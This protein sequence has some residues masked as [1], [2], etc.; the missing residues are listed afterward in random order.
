MT[1]ADYKRWLSPYVDEQLE[2]AR[3]AE[4][5]EHLGGCAG[6]RSEL[7]S[8]QRMLASLR[9]MAPVETP[10]LL[11]GIHAKLERE[12]WWQAAT[13]HFLAPWPQSLP[14]H[15][16]ALATVGL[17]VI[18]LVGVPAYLQRATQGRMRSNSDSFGTPF[19]GTAS[20]QAA[21]KEPLALARL[22]QDKDARRWAGRAG[23]G[24]EAEQAV[25]SEE[26]FRS[27]DRPLDPLAEGGAFFQ[28]QPE[29]MLGHREVV[30]GP[31]APAKEAGKIEKERQLSSDSSTVPERED[32]VR[33]QLASGKA[34]V[35]HEALSR[36]E[37]G[38]KFGEVDETQNAGRGFIAEN[39]RDKQATYLADRISL[40]TPSSSAV[41]ESAEG[42]KAEE[43]PQG[44]VVLGGAA[45][46]MTT[47]STALG[48]A[49]TVPLQVTW[50]VNDLKAGAAQVGAWVRTKQG[51]VTVSDERHL[52]ITLL[53]TDV[54]QFLQQFS[55]I[56]AEPVLAFS[57]WKAGE[58]TIAPAEEDKLKETSRAVAAPS[59]TPALSAPETGA[60]AA[61]PTPP[62]QSTLP[63]WVTI[64]LE[65]VPASE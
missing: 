22:S 31:V 47:T 64:S 29:S 36:Q 45:G 8:L 52:M 27:D 41:A 7:E 15:S 65:L 16:L 5:E 1:C 18:V 55:S 21:Q 4:L 2:L 26:P 28:N 11:P 35:D 10:G 23:V 24:A 9:A 32:A 57:H 37:A 34:V 49:A 42:R 3:R 59:T 33:M 58:P 62:L 14:A 25:R 60:P 30:A 13:R 50:Q 39:E 19:S 48:N 44:L 40:G 61:T 46:P 6:C 43:T 53:N 56:P 51:T 12:P 54:P 20:W 63:H 38:R 17:L